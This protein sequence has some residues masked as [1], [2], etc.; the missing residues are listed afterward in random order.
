MIRVDFS[1][2]KTVWV[3]QKR[4]IWVWEEG[5]EKGEE[6]VLV[7]RGGERWEGE[8]GKEICVLAHVRD[9]VIFFSFIILCL[10]LYN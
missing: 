1:E 8:E 7:E 2:K 9:E 6:V 10:K 5:E 3:A 4:S